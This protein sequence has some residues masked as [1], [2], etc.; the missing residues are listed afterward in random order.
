MRRK[1]SLILL[2]FSAFGFASSGCGKQAKEVDFE[3]LL[4]QSCGVATDQRRSFMAKVPG[5][6]IQLL[7]DAEF[8][9]A[10]R[11]NIVESAERWNEL[12]RRLTGADF[13]KV[14]DHQFPSTIRSTDPT[15]CSRGSGGS[16][17]MAM[18]RENSS[19]RWKELGFSSNVPG[20]TLR[21]YSGTEVKRQVVL[22]YT[23]LVDD[24]QF[25]SVVTHELGH[26]LGLDH[27]CNPH[28]NSD[29]YLSCS[30]VTEGHAYRAAVMFPSL[31]LRDNRSGLPE[32]KETLGANDI[33]RTSCL[34]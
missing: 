19:A 5:F 26:S 18:M 24:S 2:I 25:A 34:Y 9:I 1:I 28:G 12:G 3:A 17:T 20:A 10:Q 15:D 33:T 22:L 8:T 23:G 30:G 16:E 14:V 32:I 4:S 21:C 31:R 7:V 29:K 13:F 11:T 6:P 27:S